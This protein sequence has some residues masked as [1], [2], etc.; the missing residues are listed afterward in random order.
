M[1]LQNFSATCYTIFVNMV[2]DSMEV[3]MDD[4]SVVRDTTEACLEQ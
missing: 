3:F 2:E 1:F 4:F